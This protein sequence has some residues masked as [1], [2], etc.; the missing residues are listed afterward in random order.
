MPGLEPSPKAEAQ[1][2]TGKVALGMKSEKDFLLSKLAAES[3]VDN[4]V[5]TIEIQAGCGW[6][7]WSG[8]REG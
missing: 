1:V 7:T 3:R 4:T 6:P 8:W 5:L 2:T